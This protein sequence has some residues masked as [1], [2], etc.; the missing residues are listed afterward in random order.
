MSKK[1]SII[2]NGIIKE[3][4]VF[5]FLL[6]LCPALA[7]STDTLDAIGMG[8]ATTFVLVGSNAAISLLRKSIPFKVR[9]PCFIVLIA[10]FTTVVRLLVQ[11]YVYELYTALGIFLPLIAVNCIVFARAEIFASKNNLLDSVI[12]AVSVGI[13]FTFAMFLIASLREILGSGT[14]FKMALP[15]LN[16]NKIEIFILAPGGFIVFGFLIAVINKISKGKAIKSSD[17]NCERCP[18]RA[19]CTKISSVKEEN[20]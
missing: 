4:P 6:G 7:V 16:E 11:A 12:D 9:I 17:F 20:K 1:V 18:S 19:T 3:N 14:W 10:G 13:G 2:Y 5:V 15:V 8:L